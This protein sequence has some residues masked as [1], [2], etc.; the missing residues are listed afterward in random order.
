LLKSVRNL[1]QSAYELQKYG[2]DVVV[3]E[4]AIELLIL[5]GDTTLSAALLLL[6]VN[7]NE[8]I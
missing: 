6:L 3:L 2:L 7:F 4:D 5:G 8:Q 1:R